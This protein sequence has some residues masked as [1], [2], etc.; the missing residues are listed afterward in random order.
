MA[1][2]SEHNYLEIIYNE[3]GVHLAPPVDYIQGQNEVTSNS[4]NDTKLSLEQ[5]VL[6]EL[7]EILS[8][9]A[10]LYFDGVNK[11]EFLDYAYA[12]APLNIKLYYPRWHTGEIAA[13][14]QEDFDY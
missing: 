3:T 10:E 2:I 6:D 13:M 4:L 5:D 1:N 12:L 11:Q 14:I 8:E 7:L 9:D